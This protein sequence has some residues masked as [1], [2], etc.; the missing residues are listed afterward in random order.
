MLA[1]PCVDTA[2]GQC[3]LGMNYFPSRSDDL[4]KAN[5]VLNCFEHGERDSLRGN[6][7]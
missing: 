7:P 6:G 1:G 5:A 2:T 3:K 4:K